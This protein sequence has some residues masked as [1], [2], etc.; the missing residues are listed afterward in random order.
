MEEAYVIA[1]QNAKKAAERNK[2]HYD[3]KVRNSVL[4]PGERV[5]VKN[6]TPRGGPGKFCNYWEDAVHTVVRQMGSEM[7]FLRPERGK[8]RSRVLHRNLLIPCDHLP[9][10]KQPDLTKKDKKKQ[11]KRHEPSQIEESDE[12]SGDE[13]ELHYEPLQ[14]PTVPVGRHKTSVEL[15]RELEQRHLP[16]EENAETQVHA[17]PPEQPP[18]KEQLEELDQP[19]ENLP[20]E[21][22]DL[23]AARVSP[24][25][26]A[27]AEPEE[28]PYQVPQRERH[29]PRRITY[30]Q[31]GT[32]FC[33]SVQPT[34][35]VF[36]PAPGMVPWLPSLQPYY[37]QPPFMYGL[38]QA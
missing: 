16:A 17:A 35:Q 7:G 19:A 29:P 23:P 8:G 4:Q 5:L 10:E 24:S 28:P 36:Y 1:N 21:D 30:D 15:N 32:P 13:Y 2:R 31:L 3:T 33:Y 12:D 20:R 26:R 34:A 6:V 18:E 9:F 27:A 38:Q 14:P 37:L 11:K 22:K 25:S